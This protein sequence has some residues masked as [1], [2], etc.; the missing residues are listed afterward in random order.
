[1]PRRRIDEARW[2]A[3]VD[4]EATG[5]QPEDVL[6][7]A[8]CVVT[9]YQLRTLGEA[10][11]VIDP[12]PF[13]W[14][15]RL[16][17]NERVMDMHIRSGLVGDLL[18]NKGVNLPGAEAELI[19]LLEDYGKPHQFQLAGRGVS[20]FD[21]GLLKDHMPTFEGWFVRPTM[22]IGET[23]RFLKR[24]CRRDDLLYDTDDEHRLSHRGLADIHEH[25]A[26][27]RYYRDLVEQ[28]E[29]PA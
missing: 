11:V 13:D 4:L 10:T 7:E 8:A 25:I 23:R 24:V 6:L 17:A 19:A 28:I 2:L 21:R 18:A 12:K 15:K 20:W 3:W 1:M 27:T 26:E 22:D 16:E 29:R 14:M 5:D 9:D